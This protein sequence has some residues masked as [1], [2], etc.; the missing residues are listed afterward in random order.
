MTS[1]SFLRPGV[2]A[3]VGLFALPAASAG[4]LLYSMTDL[5]TLGGPESAAFGLNAS[6]QV[7]G[8]ANI[9]G[10]TVNG[11]AC[12]HAFVWDDGVMTDLGLLHGDQESVARAINDAG[13]I[14]GTSEFD[15]LFGSGTFHA[16]T[17]DG[18][19]IAPLPDLGTGESFAEDVNASGVVAGWAVDPMVS[20]DR[21]VTWTGG[22]IANVGKGESHTYNRA[23]GINDAGQLAGFAWNLFEPNDA[24]LNA[25]GW[26]TIGGTDGPFQNA[27]AYDVND[28]GLVVGL[29]AFPSGGWHAATWTTSGA[30]DAGLLPGHEYGELHSANEDGLC[31]GRTYDDTDPL[32]SHG[33]LWDGTTLHDLND[34][35]VPGSIGVVYEARE[36]NASGAIAGTALVGGVFH[37]VLLE[38]SDGSGTWTNLGHGLAGSAGVPQLVG[39]GPLV[40]ASTTTLTLESGLPAAPAVLVVGLSPLDAPFK[41]G[42]LV[43]QPDLVLSG[44][45]L[46]GSGGFALSFPWPAGVPSG[47]SVWWQTWIQDGAAP[48]GWSASDGLRSTTP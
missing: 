3:L 40:A 14:V 20:R 29:Q 2:A 18:G 10:C 19:V 38:P 34:L 48:A 7:V 28:S 39:D 16:V 42:V 5:G 24:I 37:A 17:W 9:D 32:D 1:P 26:S 11:H 47:A 8:W 35:L 13:L 41:Q 46:T 44:I 31:V 4:E 15:V 12:R 21:A 25:G 30:V 6:G 23:I 36:I 43:P 33:V 45:V 27:E 22:A